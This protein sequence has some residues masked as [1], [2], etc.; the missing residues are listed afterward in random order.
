[1][2]HPTAEPSPVVPLTRQFIQ[3]LRVKAEENVQD[4]LVSQ[5]DPALV[6]VMHGHDGSCPPVRNVPHP[7]QVHVHDATIQSSLTVERNLIP[8]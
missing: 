3:L 8:L 1:M 2:G 7:V 4:V 6:L 5:L